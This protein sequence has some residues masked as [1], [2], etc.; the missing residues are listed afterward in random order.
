MD[1]IETTSYDND[2]LSTSSEES[3]EEGLMQLRHDLFRISVEKE[4]SM[5]DVEEKEDPKEIVEPAKVNVAS[6][7]GEDLTEK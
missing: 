3:V 2:A 1:T 7:L 5:H 6:M 4:A